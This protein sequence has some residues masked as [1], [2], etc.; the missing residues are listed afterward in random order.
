M[1]ARLTTHSMFGGDKALRRLQ[2]CADCRVTDMFSATDEASIFDFTE[3]GG[4][5]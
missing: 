3:R 4:R 2:M 5:A 1:T